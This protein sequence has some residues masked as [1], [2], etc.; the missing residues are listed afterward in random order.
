MQ[1][2]CVLDYPF[3][4]DHVEKSD[5]LMTTEHPDSVWRESFSSE[6]RESQVEADSG[7]WNN[8]IGILLTIVF[9]GVTL[10]ALVV[11]AIVRWG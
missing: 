1:F 5:K 4:T 9:F 3:T 10:S 7:A 8:I 2:L 6:Q 11:W